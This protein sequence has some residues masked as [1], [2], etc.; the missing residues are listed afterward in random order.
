M[1]EK[2]LQSKPMT[3]VRT[4]DSEADIYTAVAKYE[5]KQT[6]NREENNDSN[7]YFNT[8]QKWRDIIEW[9][10]ELK[11][12]DDQP[13]E[14]I[15]QFRNDAIHL[16][17]IL[18]KLNRL[19]KI[20]SRQKKE[21]SNKKK[22][23]IDSKHLQQENLLNEWF[24]LKKE[25]SKCLQ[26]KSSDSV[27]DLVPLD[28]FCQESPIS[29]EDIDKLNNGLISDHDLHIRRLQWEL[30]Q[31][32]TQ[33]KQCDEVEKSKETI[34]S[35]I[36]E[37]S[38]IFQSILPMLKDIRNAAQPLQQS[39]GSAPCQP[40]SY[41]DIVHLLPKPLY[42]LYIQTDAYKEACKSKFTVSTNGDEEEAKRFDF[43]KNNVDDTNS[44]EEIDM[45][46]QKKRHHKKSRID[47]KSAPQK[48]LLS[49][50]PLSVKLTLNLKNNTQFI[51]EFFY[52]VN[53]NLITVTVTSSWEGFSSS[54]SRELLSP[55][56]ILDALF[57]GDNGTESPHIV[58]FHQL[59]EEKTEF[60]TL[61]VGKPY[62]W[63]Q[64]IC[65][66]DFLIP[67]SV[68]DFLISRNHIA[69]VL[70]AINNRLKTR[71]SLITQLDC[72]DLE[73]RF[74]VNGVNL[75]SVLSPWNTMSWDNFKNLEYCIPHIEFGTVT[76]NDL[77]FKRVINYKT[78]TLIVVMAIKCD[79]PVSNPIF[80]LQLNMP[81]TNEG[82]SV[83]NST[84]NNSV[85]ELEREINVFHKQIENEDINE[86]LI[87]LIGR[88][89]IC[90]E[91][92]METWGHSDFPKTK[93]ILYNIRGRTRSHPFKVVKHH[94]GIIFEHR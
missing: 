68:S 65:G 36:Q 29:D 50:H 71:L 3:I 13:K 10:H 85:R 41:P 21:R 43:N 18:K 9:I 62:I 48:N 51:M 78:A 12:K 39:F 82:I 30:E 8:L 55:S 15:E 42:Y 83:L 22:L 27:I 87:N 89:V 74:C 86:L 58:N 61:D 84:N 80:A 44:D 38:R 14:K 52:L 53:L 37:Q 45:P 67:N 46:K 59:E 47:T 54:Y 31:R 63:A 70:K 81:T 1:S 92:M 20:R 6:L 34:L 33:Q 60:N 5:E 16:F 90:F 73:R 88:L 49:K 57:P 56:S 32:Q 2:A 35:E 79:Y 69:Q 72:S 91:V 64:S 4:K 77:L 19:D 7:I 75:T 66:L 93:T 40:R 11:N 28:I 76:E 25:I 26:Y 23:E 94:S 24:Y 17:L